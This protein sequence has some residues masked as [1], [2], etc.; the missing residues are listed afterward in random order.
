MAIMLGITE[1]GIKDVCIVASGIKEARK[2]T[3]LCNFL[4]PEITAF[5]E[6]VNEKLL[7]YVEEKE[8]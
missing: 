8:E 1:K 4:D 5:E 7:T 6:L 3:G 2:L